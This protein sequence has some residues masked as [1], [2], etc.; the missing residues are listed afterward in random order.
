MCRSLTR[1]LRHDHAGAVVDPALGEQLAHAGVHDR[2]AG[3]ALLPGAEPRSLRGSSSPASG[4]HRS[5]GLAGR[6]GLVPEH[7][8]V[9]LAPAELRPVAVG[10]GRPEAARSASSVR[11]WTS[12]YLRW[13]DIAD[14]PWTPAGRASRRSRR[15]RRPRTPASALAPRARRPRGGSGRRGPVRVGAARCGRRQRP[16]RPQGRLARRRGGPA[17][18][19]PGPLERTEDLEGRSVPARARSRARPRRATPSRRAAGRRGEGCRDGGVTAAAVHAGVRAD[20]DSIGAH[21]SG[22]PR[23]DDRGVA[24]RTTRRPPVSSRRRRRGS[25]ATSAARRAAALRP[26]PRAPGR[27]RRAGRVPDRRSRARSP[28]A[29]ASSAGWSARRRSRRNHK[30][31]ATLRD[32][33]GRYGRRAAASDNEE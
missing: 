32:R 15:A 17:V 1:K 28:A 10:S 14:V 27:P 23:D 26:A 24:V 2:V 19:E 25:A 20:V 13:A 29:A 6:S 33:S 16:P 5:Q 3:A 31:L 9:E 7:V 8:G 22:Q 11:G 12:P 21:L 18:G 4:R 30:R